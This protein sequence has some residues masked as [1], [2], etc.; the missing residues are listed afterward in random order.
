[1]IQKIFFSI[2]VF[3]LLSSCQHSSLPETLEIRYDYDRPQ[4]EFA[5]EQIR[6]ACE[7]K[8]VSCVINAT[9]PDADPNAA[10]E[11]AP[12][13]DGA[14][15][16]YF[17]VDGT[18]DAE[19]FS[20]KQEEGRILVTGGDANGMMYAG[21]DLAEAILL[22][23]D[24]NNMDASKQP[25][26]KHRGLR[27]NI[28]LDARTPSYDDTGDAAQE[29]IA[30]VWDFSFWQEYLDQMAQNRY[31]LLTLWNLHP[32]PSW[33]KVPEYPEV[34]LENVCRYNKP[35]YWDTDM[36]WREEDVQDPA[37]LE[38]I[39][40]MTI[41]EK[42]AFWKK[43][44]AHAE[45]RGIDIY[46]FHWNV[47]VNGAQGKHGIEWS[48]QSDVTID[49]IRKSVKAM[50]LTYPNIKGIGVTA[51]EHINRDLEGKYKT[52]N[53]MWHTYGRGIMDARAENPGLDVRFIFRKHWSQL[54]EIA[55]AFEAYPSEIET[56]FKY[57]RARMYSSTKPPWFDKIY[58]AD[59]EKYGTLCWLNV[60]NDDIL[61]F[62]WGDPEYA[63]EYIRH[64]PYD[65]T[66]GFY[67][68]PDGYVWG[69]DF[70]SRDPD[71][72]GRLA[73][74]KHWYRF[75]IWGRTAYD[76]GL[77]PEYWQDQL[78]LRFPEADAG[79]LYHSWRAT[80]DIISL[81]DKIHYRQN[82]YQFLP[83]GCLDRPGGFHSVDFFIKVAAM[84]LQ[85]VVSIA[86]FARA[87]G[88]VNGITPFQVA[89]SLEMAADRLMEGAA[90]IDPAGNS[91]LEETLGDFRSLAWLG[92]YYA[93]KVRGATFLAMYRLE[94]NKE[95][96]QRAIEQLEQAVSMWEK[97]AHAASS[98]YSPQLFARTRTLDWDALLEEVKGDVEIARDAEHGQEVRIE[99]DNIL[100]SR[101]SARL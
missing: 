18:L 99:Y 59:V 35:V 29:N 61:V 15:R 68:G 38:V 28:P 77:K 70:T 49:Y 100:W 37:N 53:W 33:V 32:Y 73:V 96:Q 12:D 66:P 54:D 43:V 92:R 57:S 9:A 13:K 98:L 1:M 58:R 89:D 5:L 93:R 40:E 52:E 39:L 30:T 2:V 21:I 44:F 67:M 86:D 55:K 45:D 88:A 65:L 16:L 87:K 46:L 82:D 31:N 41:D 6:Q 69:R 24:L 3:I 42:I 97:Y 91:E 27:F 14:V 62:R 10:R 83:E 95:H 20:I 51:G 17:S 11:E 48:Q 36:R 22:E 63:S 71:H 34:A 47:F 64:I 85:G 80:S 101:N 23:K 84:P 19:S 7:V 50:L 81:V 26:L 90:A 25:Y 72:L 74:D 78:R 60:R 79:S 4:L 8:G 75:R 94:G 76:P 56:S